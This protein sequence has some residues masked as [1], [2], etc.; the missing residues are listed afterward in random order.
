MNHR[1]KCLFL[2]NV[3][4]ILKENNGRNV[5]KLFES[6][7]IEKREEWGWL[8]CCS[9]YI[10]GVLGKDILTVYKRFF[11]IARCLYQFI[12]ITQ[13]NNFGYCC[14]PTTS[15]A[16]ENVWKNSTVFFLVKNIDCFTLLLNKT[17]EICVVS[18]NWFYLSYS[19]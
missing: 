13:R 15:V 5:N 12:T 7:P 16:V 18:R 2:P 4:R 14:L 8:I 6:L 17:V 11:Q 9:I 1:L 10:Q 3:C 19:I